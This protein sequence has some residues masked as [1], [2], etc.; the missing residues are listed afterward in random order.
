MQ[1][2]PRRAVLRHLERLTDELT[3]RQRARLTALADLIG[4]DGRIPMPQALGV[5]TPGGGDVKAQ[6][7]FRKFRAAL[8]EAATAAEVDLRLVSDRRKAPP[9]DRFCWFEGADV[10]SEEVA[11]RSQREARRRTA[12]E[13]V[14]ASVSEVLQP[15]VYV[16]TA[17]QASE[18]LR[19][20]ERQFVTLLTEQ[21]VALPGYRVTSPFDL[22]LGAD[23]DAERQRLRESADVVVELDSAAARRHTPAGTTARR[24]LRFAL[25]GV[26]P[27]APAP[28]GVPLC[29][30][31]PFSQCRDRAARLQ[32]VTTVLAWVDDRLREPLR[33]GQEPWTDAETAA[34]ARHES[35]AAGQ[36]DRRTWDD[37]EQESW[38]RTRLGKRPIDVIPVPPVAGET[39]LAAGLP[40]DQAPRHLGEPTRAVD[41]LLTWAL[42]ESPGARHL[43]T[44]L[45]DVGM[46]KTTT[47]KL[48]T[49]AL[50]DHRRHHGPTVPLPILFDLRD[51][52]LT[53]AR[54]GANLTRI[55]QALL[56]A[57]SAGAGPLAA[58]VLDVVAEGDCVLIFDGL[59]EVL[60]HLEPQAGQRFTR[61]LW[62][63]TEDTWQS[64]SADRRGARPSR[65]LL[66]CRTHYF[67]SIR[68]ETN[69][70]TGQHRDGPVSADYLALLMLP[71]GEEQVR[72]Y[73]SANV[74]GAD[75]DR[76]LELLDSVH[77]LR[78][79]AERPLTLRMVAEQLETVEQ[80]KL[81]GRTVRAMDL[82]ALFVAQWL[83]RDDGKHSLLPAHKELLM[84][85]LAARLWRSGRATW[86]V[87]E[88]EQWLLEFLAGRPDL[89]LHYS[90]RAPDLWK[91]DLRTAT[92]LVRQEDETFGFAHTSLREYFLARHLARA[93]ESPTEQARAGWQ[94]PVPSPETL[95]YLGQWLAGRS[96]AQRGRCTEAMAAMAAQAPGGRADA[97]AVLAFAYCL[98][99]TRSGHPTHA[100]SA[101]VLTGADLAGWHIDG[102]GR[103]L[104]LRGVT[105]A[106]AKL[107]GAV[108]RDADLS[109]ADLSGAD[110]TRAEI[111]D[112]SLDG[113]DLRRA[114][115]AGTVFRAC[116]LT[117]A[118]WTGSRTYATQ[119]LLCRPADDTRR[120]WL[121]APTAARRQPGVRLSSFPGHT[122]RLTGGAWSPDGTRILTASLDG[123]ARI[124]DATTGHHQLT[125]AGGH[126]DWLSGGAWSPDNSRVLTTSDDGT[127]RIWDAT[128]GHH[129]LT[130]NGHTSRLSGGTWSPD[131]TRILTTSND[132]TARTWDATTGHHQLTLTGH[133]GPLS[134]GAWSPDG[135]RILTTSDDGTGRSWDATTGHHLLTLIGHTSRLSA[136]VWSPDGSRILTT[137]NDRTARIWNATT[138]HHHLTLT[139]HTSQAGRLSGGAWSPDGSRILT[140]S[141]D[142]T[143]WIWDA[144]TGHHQLTLTGHTSPLSGGAW[145]P[146]GSRIL[147]TS[148][149]R[150][151]WIWEAATGHHQ[152]T[153]T[154]YTS[155]LSGGTWSPDGS[156]ILT[157][158]NDG[159]ARSWDATTGHHQLTL[160]GHTSR[161]SAG[162]WSP[163]GSRILT[164]S[165]DRTARSWDATTG[166]RHLTLTGHTSRLSAGTWSPDG[167]RI[168]TTSN[169][170]TARTWDAT[171][172]HHQLTLTGHAGPL[173]GGA[174]S[175]DGTR[176]LTTAND[177]TAR[178]WDATT[179]HHQLTLTGHTS[180]LS[181]GAWNP[182]GTRILT[183]SNDR[184]ARIW[185]ATTGHHQLTL[186]GHT[187]IPTCGAWSPDGTRI[188]T[189]SED[190]TARIW[191]ATTGHHQ[192]TLTGHTSPLTGGAWSPDSTRILTTSEDGTARIWDATTGRPVGW[193][194][195]QLPDGELAVWSADGDKLLGAS[196][197]AWRWLGWL[198]PRGGRMI[199]LPAETWG[200]LAPLSRPTVHRHDTP[201]RR[202]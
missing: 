126:T 17:P 34:R 142:G 67:R 13:P 128:T 87:D 184:T 32:F 99:A 181:G 7:T 104:D 182:D 92:F 20:W 199:R 101:S 85:D 8:D 93:L 12:D 18:A 197:E 61:M 103:R 176:I 158:S 132:R 36:A 81:D 112:S 131:S 105:L 193:R 159:T 172:G 23:V 124:W 153:L 121:M 114:N 91:E 122:G 120:G 115:L 84:E 73:L 117:D 143:A 130:L 47:V 50:L 161:L 119:A 175:P 83:E 2:L 190:R 60:V 15:V 191:D 21:V 151:A 123:T 188:L 198:V 54:E 154:S 77:N 113:A 139:G 133:A 135:S 148:E 53:V 96:D 5:A 118:R 37:S 169:D 162:T 95:D 74:P 43:C 187:R 177:R 75:A 116:N 78:E 25:E 200:P 66:S 192:L 164:T 35:A 56:D 63:A 9:A 90:A 173:A 127:A 185:N 138:G 146:D 33:P 28:E 98:A 166:H 69:H 1:R 88:V 144:A 125:L 167:T 14:P 41:R 44:L 48:F 149:D 29:A 183:T 62:R 3:P 189:T 140:T 186:T 147:T 165:N 89:E 40:G 178:T 86:Q 107:A 55:M 111:H 150:T 134:G 163:D 194:L 16:E 157:T 195:E 156:R 82:Y 110:L 179:G 170:R 76:L 79:I 141:N 26:A 46:G 106:R 108:M 145:S 100:P 24:P 27:S 57:G 39:S 19:Q 180:W 155:W 202:R 94:L 49:E 6:D 4:D 38:A 51:L 59:D 30:G 42:D 137:S 174:W 160:T 65:L 152:L 68:H 22:L 11:E 129:H 58:Q 64:R 201:L 71:F 97:A 70:F 80:A 72:A 102:G 168:L 52:P 109:R 196:E 171:T 45:G 10:T 31:R 136:G